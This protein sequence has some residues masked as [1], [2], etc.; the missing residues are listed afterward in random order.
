MIFERDKG[1]WLVE[2][3]PLQ[4]TI[5]GAALA[6]RRDCRSCTKLAA[7]CHGARFKLEAFGQAAADTRH[8]RRFAHLDAT[9]TRLFSECGVERAAADPKRSSGKVSFPGS[10]I[11]RSDAGHV[12]WDSVQGR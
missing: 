3:A 6:M 7:S 2:K 1:L 12:D 4:R 11:R 10:A 5:Q 9:T 8:R